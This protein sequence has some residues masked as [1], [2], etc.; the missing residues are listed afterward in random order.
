MNDAPLRPS[1]VIA[2]ILAAVFDFS[3]IMAIVLIVE[4]AWATERAGERVPAD[5]ASWL[6]L[7][8]VIAYFVIPQARFGVTLGKKACRLVLTRTDERP[9]GWVP[10]IVRF[11]VAFGAFGLGPV[12]AG[13]EEDALW[14]VLSILQVGIPLGIYLPIVLRADRRGLHDLAANTM[15]SSTVPP[16]SEVVDQVRK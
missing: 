6:A 3:A 9:A 4:L 15:V 12:I 13:R 10:T 14:W 7:A 2:R 1:P 11:V 8:A 5:G 16:L